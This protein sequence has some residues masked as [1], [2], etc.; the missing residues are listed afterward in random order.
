MHA[1]ASDCIIFSSYFNFTLKYMGK[2]ISLIYLLHAHSV[3]IVKTEPESKT[4]KIIKMR[5]TVSV[6]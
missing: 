6:C 2:C 3:K 5:K 4:N 1:D